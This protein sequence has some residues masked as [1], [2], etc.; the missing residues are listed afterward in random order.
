MRNLILALGIMTVLA[1]CNKKSVEPTPDRKEINCTFMSMSRHVKIYQND[2]LAFEGTYNPGSGAIVINGDITLKENAIIKVEV[3]KE[4]TDP[5][6]FGLSRGGEPIYATEFGD[7]NFTSK[8]Y[9]FQMPI[10]E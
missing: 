4:Y 9:M 5:F 7:Q 2:K 3:D 8:T 1:S 6:V 10:T